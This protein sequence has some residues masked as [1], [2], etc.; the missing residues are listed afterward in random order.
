[1]NYK[2]GT[3]YQKTMW[4]RFIVT[5]QKP[6]TVVISVINTSNQYLGEICWHPPWQQYTFNSK[7]DVIYNNGC[8]QDIAQVLSQ[9]NAKQKKAQGDPK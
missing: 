1:M 2:P 6:K 9:L 4:L 5:D 3:V 8:L 7:G